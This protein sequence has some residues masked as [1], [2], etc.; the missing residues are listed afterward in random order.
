MS[1]QSITFS[2]FNISVKIEK[3]KAPS[4]DI[5]IEEQN[6]KSSNKFI[7]TRLADLYR[8][9]YECT[10]AEEIYHLLI[11]DVIFT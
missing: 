7:H 10:M 11:I 3:L 1:E 5:Q 2:D 9:N 6:R 4:I 8:E